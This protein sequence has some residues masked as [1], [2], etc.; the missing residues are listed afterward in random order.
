MG[1]RALVIFA[2]DEENSPVVYLHWSSSVS[3]RDNHPCR[4][5]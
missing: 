3:V 5:W 2:A 4:V 1:D